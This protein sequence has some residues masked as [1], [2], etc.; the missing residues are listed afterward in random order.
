V[1]KP[2]PVKL[3][4]AEHRLV[5]L[6]REVGADDAAHRFEASGLPT[7][8][9]EAY[10]YTDLKLL[11][12][13]VPDR[14][15]GPAAA[16]GRADVTVVNG[17]MSKPGKLPKG[18][19]VE[20]TRSP[21]KEDEVVDLLTGAFTPETVRVGVDASLA[22]PLVIGLETNGDPALSAA[23]VEIAIANGA[24]AVVVTQHDST[25]GAHLALAG[26]A[27]RLGKGASLTHVAL[28][29]QDSAARQLVALDYRLDA[30]AK[31]RTL[32][33][34]AGSALSRVNLNARFLG[35]GAHADFTGINL[36]GG[37]QHHDTTLNISHA[38][39][40]TTSR[41]IFK[42]IVR[43]RGKAVVQG[44]IIVERG[45]QKTDAKLMAQGLMLSEGA[46]I[47]HKPELEI[48]ADDVVCG[49]GATCGALDE[50][51][52]FYLL[53]RGITRLEAE[54]MLIRAFVAEVIDPVEDEA[55]R[56]RLEG[57]VDASL[58]PRLRVAA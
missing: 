49:H 50:G 2:L 14:L 31:L 25:E 34:N 4:E 54:A 20:G 8:R 19:N 18:V 15:A 40:H 9:V 17:R 46:E 45:A 56:A 35:A 52:L 42:T 43:E 51:A 16:K 37:E 29:G 55:V 47:L 36:T 30:D 12:R 7:R 11:L 44:K 39:A 32:T 22:T 28:D 23:R 57:I 1:N 38:V 24:N 10:H 48:F 41:E 5:A 6:L 27:F 58:E 3:S 21:S 33:V 53:S 26:V 13:E